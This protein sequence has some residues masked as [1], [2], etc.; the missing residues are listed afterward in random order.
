MHGLSIVDLLETEEL[1]VKNAIPTAEGALQQ[2]MEMTDYTIF[3]ANCI[4]TGYGRISRLLATRLRAMGATVTITSRRS[5]HKAWIEAEGYHYC[6]TISLKDVVDS[7]DII[8]NTVPSPVLTR[9]VLRKMKREALII[10]LA[11]QPGGAGRAFR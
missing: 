5:D 9:H 1:A 4:I 7:A 11:S 2:A 6:Y 3:G 8:F 10:D